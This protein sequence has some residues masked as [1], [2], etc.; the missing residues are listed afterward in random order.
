MPQLTSVILD[1][2]EEFAGWA[3]GWDVRRLDVEHPAVR[4]ELAGDAF[5][6]GGARPLSRESR[7]RL[8]DDFDYEAVWQ[9]LAREGAPLIE[10]LV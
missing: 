5:R 3:L 4:A 10:G 6:N 1:Q 9:R 8:D 2:P 7:R